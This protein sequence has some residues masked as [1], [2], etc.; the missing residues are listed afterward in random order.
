MERIQV[1]ID[2]LQQQYNQK[3][4]AA[5]MLVTLQSLQN[6]LLALQGGNKILGT[7]KVAVMMPNGPAFNR[8]TEKPYFN[9][10]EEPIAQP[11][12]AQ[13]KQVPPITPKPAENFQKEYYPQKPAAEVHQQPIVQN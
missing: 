1:L 12:F 8:N 13:T 10:K 9:G 3:E 7:S 11:A 2:K 4:N 6:E 5:S